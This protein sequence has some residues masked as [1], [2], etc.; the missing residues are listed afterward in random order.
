MTD[1]LDAVSGVRQFVLQR[2]DSKVMLKQT[3]IIVTVT[4]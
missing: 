2:D 3:N 1:A 4:C